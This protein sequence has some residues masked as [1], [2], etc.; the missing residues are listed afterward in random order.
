VAQ[1]RL[2]ALKVNGV[3]ARA[4]V[5]DVLGNGDYLLRITTADDL[6]SRLE[7]VA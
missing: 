5:V 6:P 2:G 3:A 1:S 4:E 7:L